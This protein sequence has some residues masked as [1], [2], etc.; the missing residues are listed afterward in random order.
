MYLLR[1]HFI[2]VFIVALGVAA[3][4]AAFTVARPEHRKEVMVAPNQELPYTEVEFTAADAR[5]AFAAEGITLL[6]RIRSTWITSLGS[7]GDLMAV[8]IFGEP[9]QV[10]A[11]GFYNYTLVDGQYVRMPSDCAAGN[12]TA[13]RWHG[14]V[15]AIV[16]C[17]RD[18]AESR[19]RLSRVERAFARL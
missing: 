4:A 3:T 15:R 7:S 1:G 19:R 12:T 8:D 14:N 11:A 13:T 9:A 2:A 16:D 10:K 5:R 17:V 18:P 6:P